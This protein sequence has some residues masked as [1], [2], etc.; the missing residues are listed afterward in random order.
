MFR[1]QKLIDPTTPLM[2][3]LLGEASEESR[4]KIEEKLRSDEMFKREVENA[5][6][7]LIDAYVNLGLSETNRRLFETNFLCTSQRRQ[8][9]RSKSM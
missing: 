1:R 2:K 3:Y 4:G 6:D 5:E 9:L 7:V 8:K